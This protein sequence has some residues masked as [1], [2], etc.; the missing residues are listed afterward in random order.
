[1]VYFIKFKETVY[2]D[3]DKM[4]ELKEIAVKA[5]KKSK[6]AKQINW[7]FNKKLYTNRNANQL[8][9][10]IISGTLDSKT[11]KQINETDINRYS[12]GS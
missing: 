4:K 6:L 12:F 10:M 2:L 1:M 5:D 8:Y 9:Y 7:F 11:Y 3:E